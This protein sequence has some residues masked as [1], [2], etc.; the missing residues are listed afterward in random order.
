MVALRAWR[1]ASRNGASD[2]GHGLGQ[3]GFVLEHD[4]RRHTVVV[5]VAIVLLLLL[6]LYLSSVS[7]NYL[8]QLHVLLNAYQF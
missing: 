6:L 4:L 8:R 3:D 2:F 1:A 5:A 7:L